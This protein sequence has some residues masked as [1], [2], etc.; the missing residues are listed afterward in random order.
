M[1]KIAILPFACTPLLRL[2][3][4]AGTATPGA[5]AATSFTSLGAI[6]GSML[7]RCGAAFVQGRCADVVLP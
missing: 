4:A 1:G 2:V 6:T 7:V 5:R 3:G